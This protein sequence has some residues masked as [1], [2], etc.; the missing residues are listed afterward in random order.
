MQDYSMEKIMELAER[1]FELF[2]KDGKTKEIKNILGLQEDKKYGIGDSMVRTNMVT[3]PKDV[4]KMNWNGQDRY[5]VVIEPICEELAFC[6]T[7]Y[8]KE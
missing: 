1:Q 6:Y 2:S 3:K 4:L 7:V 8:P 5:Y